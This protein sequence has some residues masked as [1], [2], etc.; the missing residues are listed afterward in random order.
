MLAL[1]PLLFLHA[2]A[3]GRVRGALVG[4]ERRRGQKLTL[5][6]LRL[7]VGVAFGAVSVRRSFVV[8]AQ[9][10]DLNFDFRTRQQNTVVATQ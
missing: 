10:P 5:G 3:A 9:V 6:E 2:V 8:K 7:R 4:L 1:L